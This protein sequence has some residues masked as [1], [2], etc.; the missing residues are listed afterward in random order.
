MFVDQAGAATLIGPL[1]DI[2]DGVAAT[3]SPYVYRHLLRGETVALALWAARNETLHDLR[4]PLGLA[5][6]TF[7]S[8]ET[9]IAAVE[10]TSRRKPHPFQPKHLNQGDQHARAHF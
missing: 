6:A 7:G 1:V 8:A 9:T 3:F 4:N 10:A 5:Y 2:N